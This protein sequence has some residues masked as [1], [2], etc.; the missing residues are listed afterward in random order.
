VGIPGGELSTACSLNVKNVQGR[1]YPKN[2]QESVRIPGFRPDSAD[3]GWNQWRNEKYWVRRGCVGFKVGVSRIYAER[4]LLA[5]KCIESGGVASTYLHRGFVYDI[6]TM[7]CP[8]IGWC[9]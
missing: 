2:G 9:S 7:D 5:P 4:V 6:L 8:R 3:S 1:I